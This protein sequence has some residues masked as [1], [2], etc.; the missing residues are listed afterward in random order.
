MEFKKE[1]NNLRDEY[2]IEQCFFATCPSWFVGEGAKLFQFRKK[3]IVYIKNNTRT[4]EVYKTYALY[5]L[6]IAHFK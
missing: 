4:K 5:H 6:V 2:F 1:N 3:N